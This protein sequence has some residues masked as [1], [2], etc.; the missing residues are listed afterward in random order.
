MMNNMK[1]QG[2]DVASGIQNQGMGMVKDGGAAKDDLMKKV[3]GG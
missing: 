1:G 2:M 3:K